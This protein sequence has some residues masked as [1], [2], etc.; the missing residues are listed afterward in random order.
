MTKIILVRHGETVWNVEMKYQGHS[1]IALTPKG[2][3][4]ARKVGA[5]LA[6]EKIDAVYASDLS[7][8]QF[9]AEQIAKR[10]NLQVV[11]VPEFR[12]IS[13]GEWEG[14]SYNS[15]STKW[16]EQMEKFYTLTDELE[17]PGGE[18]FRQVKARAIE[19]LKRVVNSHPDQTI[20]IVSHGGTIRTILC[21]IMNI[22]LN[23]LWNIQQA[24]TAV[25]I[26]NY[27]DDN[28][29]MVELVNDVHHLVVDYEKL[30]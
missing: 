5:R 8:A 26:L 12:E 6:R 3:E 30:F 21:A 1:D 10:H 4:Q 16:P 15:I 19:A 13:F 9:T 22:H 7:R 14:L 25:N 2:Q 20:V 23:H 17:I 11:V 24:N 28:K 18:T 29:V 27:Y